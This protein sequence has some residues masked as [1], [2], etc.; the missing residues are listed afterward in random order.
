MDDQIHGTIEQLVAEEHEL[1]ERESRLAHIRTLA[2]GSEKRPWPTAES[3]SESRGK[4]GKV[5]RSLG[6]ACVR[7]LRPKPLQ[8][9]SLSERART[10][11]NGRAHLPCRRSRV[12]VPSSA[13]RKPR[14]SG[15]FVVSEVNDRAAW[16]QNGCTRRLTPS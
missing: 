3:A 13:L 9:S 10:G 11:A 5:R 6:F 1:W 16:L 4:N 14:K 2:R 8:T 12:R 7:S 15:A